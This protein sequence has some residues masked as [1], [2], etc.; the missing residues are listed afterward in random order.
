MWCV[1]SIVAM[2]LTYNNSLSITYGGFSGLFLK[3]TLRGPYLPYS[4]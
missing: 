1:L 4:S 3:A 2:L